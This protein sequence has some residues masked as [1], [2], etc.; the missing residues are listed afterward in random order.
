[1]NSNLLVYDQADGG[2]RKATQEEIDAASKVNKFARAI[3]QVLDHLKPGAYFS[4]GRRC[5]DMVYE[6]LSPEVF[7]AQLVELT[8]SGNEDPVNYEEGGTWREA[9]AAAGLVTE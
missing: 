9:M 7:W 1:M 5:D 3:I 8:E 4:I 6:A 2:L